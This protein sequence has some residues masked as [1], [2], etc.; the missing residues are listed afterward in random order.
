MLSIISLFSKCTCIFLRISS[1][2]CTEQKNFKNSR[3]IWSKQF[4]NQNFKEYNIQYSSRRKR[5]TFKKLKYS[6]K[7]IKVKEYFTILNEPNQDRVQYCQG[8]WTKLKQISTFW[9]ISERHGFSKYFLCVTWKMQTKIKTR[10]CKKKKTKKTRWKCNRFK[11]S[12]QFEPIHCRN[13]W[14]PSYHFCLKS[15]TQSLPSIQKAFM[16]QKY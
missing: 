10:V 16:F 13:R 7:L 4:E 15:C 9:M 3:K 1:N 14:Q 5:M 6:W 11:K 8:Q 12:K 2:T